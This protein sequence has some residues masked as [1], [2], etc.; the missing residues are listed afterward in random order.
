MKRILLLALFAASTLAAQDVSTG[1]I[2]HFEKFDSKL[3]TPRNVDVWLPD[4]YSE[5]EKYAVLYM[6]DGQM[7]FDREKTWNH[8][9]WEADEVAGEL[10]RQDATRKFIIVGI[11]SL[12]N[13]RHSDYFP[14]KALELLPKATQDSILELDRN[15]KPLFENNKVDSD[16]YL[17]FIVTEL[18]PFIDKNFSTAAG[19]SDTFIAGSSMGGLISFY[20]VCEYPAVF[21]GA[22]CLSTH[23]PGLFET[24][25]NP[26]PAAFF[27]YFAAHLPDPKTHKFYFDHGDQT[28]DAQYKP[29]QDKMDAIMKA[30]GYTDANFVSKEFKGLDHS[31]TSWAVRLDQPLYFLLGK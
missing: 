5:K 4:G 20:A 7:L 18:K 16:N 25:D 9:E 11:S 30:K 28:L 23:W 3:V 8:Q 19:Q 14:Q 6:H 2:R 15:G 10:I 17:K 24:E 29:L 22:A 31:E 13:S 27:K 21:G 26:V 1:T 12:P